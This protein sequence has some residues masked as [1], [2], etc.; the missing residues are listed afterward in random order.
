MAKKDKNKFAF[1]TDFQQEIL[2]YI[3][4][5]KNGILALNQ[6]KDSYFT[7]INHQVIAKA[8]AKLSKK[9]KRIPK[10]ASVLNQEIQDLLSVKGIADLVT[11]DDLVEIKHTVEKTLFRAFIGWR[12]YP[13]KG[14]EI[15]CVC[16]NEGFE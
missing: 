12:G 8:L 10:N 5:D 3:I 6:V 16:S 7:L 11:K 15:F 1:G 4:K 2:H 14:F 13:R 9:N